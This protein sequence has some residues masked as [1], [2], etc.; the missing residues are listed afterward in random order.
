MQDGMLLWQV[1]WYTR[2][3]GAIPIPDH[4]L[5][6]IG[7]HALKSLSTHIS[8]DVPELKQARQKETS[9]MRAVRRRKDKR[10]ARKGYA[11]SFSADSAVILQGACADSC[12]VRARLL[13]S[14]RLPRFKLQPERYELAIS[15]PKV[16]CK[17]IRGQ[18][19]RQ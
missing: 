18:V 13:A 1:L 16:G 9:D 6:V 8:G 2:R 15:R 7:R 17:P 12:A 5:V 14:C 10:W 3:Y 11:D 19:L 4:Q